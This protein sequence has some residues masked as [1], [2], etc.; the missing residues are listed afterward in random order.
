MSDAQLAA[1]IAALNRIATS[2]PYDL[3]AAERR[4]IEVVAYGYTAR[5]ARGLQDAP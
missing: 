4:R 5:E 3:D 1:E 2:K